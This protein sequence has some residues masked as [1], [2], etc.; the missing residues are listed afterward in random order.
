MLERMVIPKVNGVRAP[1]GLEPP[2]EVDAMYRRAPLLLYLTAEPFEYP[3]SDWPDSV[4]MVGPVRVGSR[5]HTARM[6]G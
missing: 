3:P 4:V 6:A 1:L 5:N 2:K